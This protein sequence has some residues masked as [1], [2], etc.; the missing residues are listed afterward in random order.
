MRFL[1][2]RHPEATKVKNSD[3]CLPLHVACADDSGIGSAYI[4]SSDIYLMLID[5]YPEA[6]REFDNEGSLPLHHACGSG[7]SIKVIKFLVSLYLPSIRVVSP[8][9]GLPIHQVAK[10]FRG[11]PAVQYLEEM[12][13]ESLETYI[14]GIGL[15]LHCAA[16][17]SSKEIFQYL[18]N[19]RYRN[20]DAFPLHA[21]LRDHDLLDKSLIASRFLEKFARHIADRNSMG[22]APLHVAVSTKLDIGFIQTLISQDMHAMQLK[23]KSNSVPLH[24]ALRHGDPSKV[25]G[26]LLNQ[27]AEAVHIAD[28]NNFLPLHVASRHGASLDIVERLVD[29]YEESVTV[30][31][32]KGETPL[33]KACR[34]GHLALVEFLAQKSTPSVRVPNSNGALPIFI[35]CQSSGKQRRSLDENAFLGAI[36]QL[37]RKHPEAILPTK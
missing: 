9:H 22:C 3:D 8:K 21:I 5:H 13:S 32:D 35:L 20:R 28:V 27:Y 31:D 36:W 16:R 10:H 15:P 14:A 33:H 29:I 30:T 26:L 34:G 6:V 17:Q 11:L 4:C 1:L 37:L 24:Y 18:L 23:D 12:A 25:A 2:T 7:L 19:A